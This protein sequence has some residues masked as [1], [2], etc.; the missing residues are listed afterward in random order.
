MGAAFTGRLIAMAQPHDLYFFVGLPADLAC[1]AVGLLGSLGLSPFPERGAP[2]RKEGLHITIE[3][4]GRFLDR[5]PTRQLDLAMAA[6]N[7]VVAEPF[8]IRLDAV[9][10]SAQPNGKSMAQLTGRA[11]GLRGICGFEHSLAQA[12]RR[13]GFHESQIRRS[14]SPHVTLDYQHAPFAKRAIEPFA[15]R[16]SEFMLV[17]SLYGLSEHV[18]LGRWPLVSRQQAFDW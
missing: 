9:Q 18:V 1:R 3:K 16:V 8:D 13:V 14:F 11:A 4:M 7:T 2:M 12:M 15:W 6:G 5:I 17:D 10:S